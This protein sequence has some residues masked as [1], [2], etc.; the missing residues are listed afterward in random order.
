MCINIDN[1]GGIFI[2]RGVALTVAPKPDD[3]IYPSHNNMLNMI[4]LNAKILLQS[5][6][7]TLLLISHNGI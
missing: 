3:R 6:V 7:N 2:P 5:V 1:L 4:F